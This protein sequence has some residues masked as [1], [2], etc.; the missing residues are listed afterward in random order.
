MNKKAMVLVSLMLAL[1]ALA[2]CAPAPA[3]DEEAQAQITE[4]EAQLAAAMEEGVSQEELDALQAELDAAQAAL[5][6][7]QAA[8]EGEPEC[9]PP[10]DDPYGC[11]DPTGQRVTFWHQHSRERE[12]EL[13]KIVNDFNATNEWGITVVAEYQGGYGDIFNKMLGVLATPDVPS[14]VVAYQNQSATYALVEGAMVN[15]NYLVDHPTWGLTDEEKAD[16]FPGF[17][18]QDVFPSFGNA[19][20]GFPPN[21]SMEM[22]YYNIDWLAELFAAGVI[23]FEGPPTTPEQFKEAACAAVDNP[24]S[25]ATGDIT[26]SIGYELSIDASRFATWTFAFGGNMFDYET[27][28]YTYDSDAAIAAMTYLQDLFNEG[29]AKVVTE[30][31]GDQSNFGAGVTLFTVGSTSGLPYYQ[32]AVEAGSNMTW[33]VAPVPYTGADP[34]TNIYGASVT[35]PTTDRDQEL[36]AWLF[37]KWYTSPEIQ[38]RWVM[39]SNYFPV[40]QSVAEG[41][42]DY[43]AENPTY[44]TAFSYLP[45]GIFEP[46]VPGYD[47]VRDIAE[48]AMAAIAD[49]ADV[50]ETLTQLTIEGNEEL[51]AQLEQ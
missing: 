15:M 21:R 36:A 27:G 10:D 25:A 33:S 48:E 42:G 16:F 41:L 45:Y 17:Y 14:L 40:R 34:V 47:F 30:S 28:Q 22:M 32:D 29:C 1:V 23:S 12:T 49:G 50:V 35:I 8:D 9:V 26:T 37:I 6:A 11:A 43:F 39:A 4:L 5:E 44:E 13:L 19:R 46:P 18:N 20:H 51:A 3:D 38:A 31:Y 2:A 24:F 7:A